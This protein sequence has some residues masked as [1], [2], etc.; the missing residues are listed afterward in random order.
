MHWNATDRRH[1][2]AFRRIAVILLALADIAEGFAHRSGPF[3]RLM[4]WL[5]CR[6]QTRV[7]DLALRTCAD[8]QMPSASAGSP[9]CLL[10]GAGEPA[11]LAQGFRALAAIFFALSRQASQWLRTARLP[12]PDELP[13]DRR[14]LAGFGHGPWTPSRS[15]HDT[16]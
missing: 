12:A 9:V 14:G 8:A 1:G 13:A 15:F 2:E 11:R 16:S 6:A 7:R 4:L 5:M 10:G 3:S